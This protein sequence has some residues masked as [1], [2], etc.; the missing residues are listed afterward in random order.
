MTMKKTTLIAF[1]LLTLALTACSSASTAANPASSSQNGAAAGGLP[2]ATQL[3]IGTLKLEDSDQAVTA[4][5]ATELLPLWQTLQVLYDSDTA[6]EQ[7][8]EALT[9]Q[10]Q[11]TMTTE[12]TEAITAMNLTRQDMMTVLQEQ[13]LTM[14]GGTA[15]GQN[16]GTQSGT[17]E[18]NSGGGFGPG[19][20]VPPD[21][22][23]QGGGPGSGFAGGQGSGLT[24]DQIATAQALRS[25]SGG[26]GFGSLSRIPTPLIQ[27]IIQL[28]QEKSGL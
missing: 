8:I 20:G 2:A 22:G 10:I 17:T 4:E 1:I 27:A 12:Q 23:F 16:T 9:T 6:A 26:G 14:G 5:Q 15:G 11:E 13:G 21:G 24:P 7:E 28:L 18:R 25:E 3:A 19:G